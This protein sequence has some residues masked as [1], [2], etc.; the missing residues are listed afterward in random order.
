[1][2]IE[3]FTSA[4]WTVKKEESPLMKSLRKLTTVKEPKE[5]VAALAS[6]DT[7]QGWTAV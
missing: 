1:M 3:R 2:T 4:L 6:D 5:V 7:L